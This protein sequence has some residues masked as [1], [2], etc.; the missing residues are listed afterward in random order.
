MK[1]ICKQRHICYDLRHGNDEQLPKVRTASFGIETV[2]FLGN[3]IY[4]LLPGEVKDSRTLPI[5][6]K[7]MRCW[8]CEKGSC[9]LCQ[10][11]IPQ[12]GF[13]TAKIPKFMSCS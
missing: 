7:Q 8:N 5:F 13:I 4:Q 12:V 9:R 11:Y 6:K 1:D 3:R 2:A 10:E